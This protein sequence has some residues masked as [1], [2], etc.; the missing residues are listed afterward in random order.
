MGWLLCL[1]CVVTWYGPVTV[2]GVRGSSVHVWCASGTNQVRVTCRRPSLFSPPRLPHATRSSRISMDGSRAY[3]PRRSPSATSP[4]LNSHTLSLFTTAAP[5]TYIHTP[6][7]PLNCE[8][9]V[10]CQEK[11][12]LQ[13]P[14]SISSA[15]IV[16]ETEC[17]AA[18]DFTIFGRSVLVILLP[19]PFCMTLDK[20]RC[21]REP[22]L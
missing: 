15:P 21:A 19:H 17:T 2:F 18:S 11:S 9:S 1:V 16:S 12:P 14:I 7:V 6:P 4:L 5:H 3:R 13:K 22:M 20:L 8:L 10:L